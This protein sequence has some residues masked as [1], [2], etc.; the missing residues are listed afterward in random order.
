[1]SSSPSEK[2]GSD[3]EMG[4]ANSALPTPAM[5]EATPTFVF[6]FLSFKERLSRRSAEKEGGRIQPEVPDIL[7]SLA[8]STSAG[9]NKSPGDA[10]PLTESAMVPVQF[11]E[12]SAQPSNSSTTPI[13][14]PKEEKATEFMPPSLD[15]KEIVLGLPAS[16]AAPLT[17]SRKR[18][19]AATETVKKRRCT[20]GAEGEPS[21]P[22]SQHR[23]KAGIRSSSPGELTRVTAELAGEHNHTTVQLAGELTGT[24]VELAGRVQPHDGSAH[25]RADRRNG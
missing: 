23:A 19:G 7:S 8:M 9:G 3:V 20:A 22:L 25:R 24:M 14:A 18:T 1:M 17:K 2:K 21:R 5:H 10:T 13:P 6:G 15:R 11:S 12:V 4:E 16:S